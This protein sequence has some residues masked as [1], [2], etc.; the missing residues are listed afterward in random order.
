MKGF[1][2]QPHPELKHVETDNSGIDIEAPRGTS[3]RAIFDGTVSAIFK[4]P[5]FNTI[6]MIRH[7]EYISIYAGLGTLSVKNGQKVTSGQ[8]IGTIFTDPDNDNRSIL[9]FEIRKER[10]KLNPTLWVR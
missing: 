1:G 7:G 8:A 9:H 6:V 2:R 5:G 4:Q 10:Q 3:A